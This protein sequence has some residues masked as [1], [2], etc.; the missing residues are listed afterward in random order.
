MNSSEPI[1]TCKP[2]LKTKRDW[3][4]VM[5]CGMCMGA[6]D[7]I[8]GFSGGT[9]AFITGIYPDLIASVVSFNGKALRLLAS[10]RFIAFFQMVGWEFLIALGIGISISVASLARVI[11]AILGDPVE[12]A[13][14][15]AGFAGLVLASI[16]F[17]ARQVSRW[18]WPQFV[19]LAVGCAFAFAATSAPLRP[20][21]GG[22]PVYDVVLRADQVPN[23]AQIAEVVNYDE[24]SHR[25]LAVP[26]PSVAV[27]LAKGIVSADTPAFSHVNNREGTVQ[28]FV[29]ARPAPK[30]DAWLFF[31]GMIAITALLLPGMSGCYMLTILGTYPIIIGALSDLVNSLLGLQFDVDA[32]FILMSLGLGVLVGLVT[33]SRVVRWLLSNYRNITVAAMTGFML[34]A[35]RV[36]WPFWSYEYELLPLRLHDG[37]Q[38]QL[39]APVMPDV[40]S[41]YFWIAIAM[42][43]LGFGAVLALEYIAGKI[44]HSDP[45]ARI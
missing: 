32:F 16:L 15:F 23:D 13:Y 41:A 9:V 8:P 44:P 31:C 6:A 37:P 3:F 33:F 2:Q 14:L 43:L 39:L 40:A 25:L 26:Q 36:V 12:R 20:M 27:M 34:G 4:R 1:T 35:L 30:F 24:Q 18:R 29:Q 45:R 21:A 22:A 11:H 19:S 17:C 38:L 7:L 10:L 28:D 5:A 42:T